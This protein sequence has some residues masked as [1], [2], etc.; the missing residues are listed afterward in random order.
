[1]NKVH[2]DIKP[3]NIMAKDKNFSNLMLI[4]FNKSINVN[5]EYTGGTILYQIPEMS[6]KETIFI[7]SQFSHDIYQ[8]VMTIFGIE[9][10]ENYILS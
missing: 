9:L 8:F 1:M 6:N 2:L 4:D 3:S 10:G 7:K 5:S